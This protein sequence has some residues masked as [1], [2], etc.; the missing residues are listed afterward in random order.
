MR[1]SLAEV[2]FRLV[3]RKL[4]RLG[5]VL[6][7]GEVFFRLVLR[8]LSRLGWVLVSGDIFQ[9]RFCRLQSMGGSSFRSS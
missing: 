8:K 5:W 1:I 6:V 3:L 4:S 9:V 7:S 2:F